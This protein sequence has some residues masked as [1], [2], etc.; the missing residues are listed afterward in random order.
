MTASVLPAI[1]LTVFFSVPRFYEK[2]WD[3]FTEGTAGRLYLS[4]PLHGLGG[5][6]RKAL[7]PI[8]RVSLLRRAGLD[9]CAQ[10]IAGSAPCPDCLLVNFRD[11]GIEI[12]NAYGLTEAPLVT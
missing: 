12:H 4:L 6:L 11:L 2:V 10:L 7:R 3:R 8:L 5:G 1:R 9:K